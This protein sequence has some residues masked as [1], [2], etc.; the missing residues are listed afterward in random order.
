MYDNEK[1]LKNGKLYNNVP[2][3]FVHF[4]RSSYS[5]SS[6]NGLVQNCATFTSYVRLL[7]CFCVKHQHLH[8][9]VYQH[10]AFSHLW[11]YFK[12]VS[13]NLWLHLHKAD[14]M[15]VQ[16]SLLHMSAWCSMVLHVTELSPVK[17]SKKCQINYFNG[18]LSD[19][20][21]TMWMVLFQLQQRSRFQEWLD[22]ATSVA[23]ANCQGKEGGFHGGFKVLQQANP[24]LNHHQRKFKLLKTLVILILMHWAKYDCTCKM[25][26]GCWK[27]KSQRQVARVIKARMCHGGCYQ[28]YSNCSLGR[29][30]W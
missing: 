2:F 15:E 1:N 9:A 14:E 12:L 7:R 25:M 5:S 18:K 19:G 8:C 21:K 27:F 30:D 6:S 20:Q 11:R 3:I 23:V 28:D 29:E 10:I 16:R 24:S 26:H 22:A 17:Y 13:E 4:F